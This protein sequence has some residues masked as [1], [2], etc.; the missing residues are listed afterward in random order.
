MPLASS[1]AIL[2]VSVASYD[3]SEKKWQ[4]TDV[5]GPPPTLPTL[6][7][8][9]S[10]YRWFHRI[11]VTCEH[12]SHSHLE[13]TDKSGFSIAGELECYSL[14]LGSNPPLNNSVRFQTVTHY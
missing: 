4:Y 6:P 9:A 3:M 11:K 1:Q 8:C 13:M 7:A 10:T 5:I 14:H 2:E 12:I